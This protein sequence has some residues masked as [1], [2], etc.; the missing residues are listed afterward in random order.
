MFHA[1]VRAGIHGRRQNKIARAIT[2]I[3]YSITRGY[4]DHYP[5]TA[6]ADTSR[7]AFSLGFSFLRNNAPAAAPR[8]AEIC[9]RPRFVPDTVGLDE[10]TSTTSS[11]RSSVALR[12]IKAVGREV[13]ERNAL[14]HHPP[15][16]SATHDRFLSADGAR[17]ILIFVEL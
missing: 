7:K 17:L 5:G 2:Y 10:A 1:R 9:A 14:V 4:V 8:S 11:S 12:I 3:E 16:P 6:V 15:R 13:V